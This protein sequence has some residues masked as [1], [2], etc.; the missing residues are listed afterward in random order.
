[1]GVWKISFVL[2]IVKK[3]WF[4][5]IDNITIIFIIHFLR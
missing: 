1:M 5:I 4:S 2:V 3:E